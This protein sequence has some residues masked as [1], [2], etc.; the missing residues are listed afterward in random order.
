MVAALITSEL[1]LD[2]AAAIEWLASPVHERLQPPHLF[3]CTRELACGKRGSTISSLVVEGCHISYQR[4]GHFPFPFNQSGKF[5]G[6]GRWRFA[7]AVSLHHAYHAIIELDDCELRM[8]CRK[9]G[10]RPES[11]SIPKYKEKQG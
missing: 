6:C 3:S 9:M 7:H 10:G 2:C 1:K 5:T 11:D 4:A 8:R